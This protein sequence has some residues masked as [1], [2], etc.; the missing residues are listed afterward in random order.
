MEATGFFRVEKCLDVMCVI[1]VSLWHL[2]QVWTGEPERTGRPVRSHPGNRRWG[3]ELAVAV[4][5]RSAA[6]WISCKGEVNRICSSLLWK[7]KDGQR[8]FTSFLL[9]S[10]RQGAAMCW[11]GAVVGRAS[12]LGGYEFGLGHIVVSPL[13]DS[14]G[15]RSQRSR[16]L[17]WLLTVTWRRYLESW[18][19]L[20]AGLQVLSG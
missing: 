1:T 13:A 7:S 8:C 20:R 5:G 4:E 15:R 3:L 14:V 18:Q 11:D 9:S 17:G 12:A 16:E 10:Q 19:S 2:W 6:V